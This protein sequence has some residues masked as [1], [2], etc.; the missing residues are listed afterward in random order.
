MKRICR[1]HNINNCKLIYRF[2]PTHTR[3]LSFPSQASI[4][5]Q[6]YISLFVGL[7][8]LIKEDARR[9]AIDTILSKNK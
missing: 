7:I 8:R 1:Q 3:I 5:E 6:D 9:E 2:C 4:T